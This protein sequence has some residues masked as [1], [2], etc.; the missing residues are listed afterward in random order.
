MQK[1]KKT[2]PR[3]MTDEF[4]SYL[5]ILYKEFEDTLR[6]KQIINGDLSLRSARTSAVAEVNGTN[7]DFKIEEDFLKHL[8]PLKGKKAPD[9][10]P[11]E[12]KLS[13]IA[14]YLG[15]NDWK[16][17]IDVTNKRMIEYDELSDYLHIMHKE[18]EHK[19]EKR[20]EESKIYDGLSTSASW[21]LAAETI[22]NAQNTK[23]EANFFAILLPLKENQKL[24]HKFDKSNLDILVKFLGYRDWNFFKLDV[25]ERRREKKWFDPD[26]IKVEKLIPVEK[27]KEKE[28]DIITIGWYDEHFIR[29]IYRGKSLFEI[30]DVSDT[31]NKQ[32]GDTFYAEKFGIQYIWH[33]AEIETENGKKSI[34]GYPRFPKIEIYSPFPSDA[35]HEEIDKA[36]EEIDEAFK[37]LMKPHEEVDEYFD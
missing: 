15:Y 23:I 34:S 20:L 1:E 21:N 22:N 3:E 19:L 37:G 11:T 6:R 36:H 5:Y 4:I 25:E 28:G 17:F 26:T 2:N 31:I 7:E 27:G 30:V 29:V 16:H 24:I 12:A 13:I 8:Y 10:K 18:L 9:H 33:Y 14:I 32:I 35:D